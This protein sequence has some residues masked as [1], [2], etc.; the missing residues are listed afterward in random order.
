MYK[1]K[2]LNK[3]MQRI[4]AY[5][6]GKLDFNDVIDEDIEKITDIGISG[7]TINGK[8]SEI[9]IKSLLCFTNLEEVTLSDFAITKEDIEVIAKLSK[10]KRISFTRCSFEEENID[11][12]NIEFDVFEL[13]SCE[14]KF[15]NYPKAKKI[16]IINSTVDFEKI[17]FSNAT[18]IFIGQSCIYN[19]FDLNEYSNILDISLDGS[20]I[21]DKSEKEL[22]DIKVSKNTR[23]SHE[24]N[25]YLMD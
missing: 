1:E 5:K 2:I 24:E 10:I 21:Y 15:I 9:E 14:D 6:C 22:T 17:D 18:S 16:C 20:T 12:K 8:I 3:E 23:Y 13:K 19:A 7:R 25:I 11:L 4:V